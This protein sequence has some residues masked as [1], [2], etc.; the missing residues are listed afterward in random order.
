MDKSER[1]LQRANADLRRAQSALSDAVLCLNQLE[2]PQKGAVRS[3]VQS[4]T[5]IDSA[6]GDVEKN[7]A[8]VEFAT[9]QI[10]LAKKALKEAMIEF[11]KFKYLETQEIQAKLKLEKHSQEKALDEIAG[12]AFFRNKEVS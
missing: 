3:L 11:E 10:D 12:Q 4:R 9:S 8:W 1:D 5:L 7:R 2:L 6:R